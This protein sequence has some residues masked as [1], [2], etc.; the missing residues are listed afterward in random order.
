[1]PSTKYEGLSYPTHFLKSG[2]SD[3]RNNFLEYRTTQVNIF[4]ARVR[5][6]CC[7]KTLLMIH[8]LIQIKQNLYSID[9][10]RAPVVTQLIVKL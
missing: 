2:G 9:I 1:M 4:C 6:R 8:Y 7:L 10:F 3:I 5:R